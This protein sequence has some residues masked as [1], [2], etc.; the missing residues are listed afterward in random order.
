MKFKINYISIF[1][2]L[3]LLLSNEMFS[4]DISKKMK[5]NS[6]TYSGKIIKVNFVDKAGREHNDI[7]NY[8]LETESKQ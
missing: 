8:F 1:L 3:F 6:K 4:Q 7:F 2:I 5:D